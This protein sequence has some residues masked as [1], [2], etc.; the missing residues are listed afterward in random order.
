MAHAK[1]IAVPLEALANPDRFLCK[2]EILWL[3]RLSES[4]L[5]ERIRHGLFPPP[6][7]IDGRRPLWLVGTF[8]SWQSGALAATV[9]A[10]KAE[11]TR[12]LETAA[13]H[14]RGELE[15]E[16]RA[17]VARGRALARACRRDAQ[18]GDHHDR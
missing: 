17:L 3:T 16:R 7:M 15:R 2:G 4:A 12:A 8:K 5:H 14:A 9:D 18:A 10:R 11:I 1:S 6:D 13:P